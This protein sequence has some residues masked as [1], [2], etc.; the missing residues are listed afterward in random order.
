MFEQNSLRKLLS[1]RDNLKLGGLDC[2]PLAILALSRI[3][4]HCCFAA[5]DGIYK[6]PTTSKRALLPE[7]AV[8]KVFELLN[9]DAQLAEVNPNQTSIYC[10]SSENMPEVA[11][12]SID[13]IVTSPPYLNNFDFAE[14][15]RMYLYF[16]GMASSWGDITDKVR[17]QLI[18]NTTTALKGHRTLQS[19]YR[20]SLPQNVQN[21][22][23]VV[24]EALS[25][26]RKEKQGKK[27]YDLLVF[28]YLSQMQSILEECLRVL[29][30]GAPLHMMVSDAAL[31]G[32]HLPAPQWLGAI[33]TDL[34]Y[35]DVQCEMVRPRG[36]RW[37]LNKR[38][39][40]AKG[41]GEYYLFGS[42][43]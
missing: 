9:D 33:M 19:R 26:R 16:W 2:N 15:T 30:P 36:H 10:K 3:L 14:M 24:V 5:T 39:G 38:E 29:K 40:S 32:I 42:A 1:A 6:A 4:D 43:A 35:V 31:Y 23:D 34:G 17:N 22:A 41:L 12:N 8:I 25:F 7:D 18:V 13:L 20:E 37:T 11:S 28:P 21:E 27:E